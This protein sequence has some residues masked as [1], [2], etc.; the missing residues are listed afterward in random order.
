[1]TISQRNK[2]IKFFANFNHAH[3]IISSPLGLRTIVGAEG[4][5][6]RDYSFLS[7]VEILLVERAQVILMQNWTHLLEVMQ[8]LNKMPNYDSMVNPIQSIRDGFL[9]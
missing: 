9:R 2:K 6:D 5:A 1:M 8:A 4:E 3:I 7:S